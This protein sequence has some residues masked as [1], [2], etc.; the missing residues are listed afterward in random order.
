[1]KFLYVSK[2]GNIW[3]EYSTRS[4]VGMCKD[5][6]FGL[7]KEVSVITGM[8]SEREVV[9]RDESL[10]LVSISVNLFL[11]LGIEGSEDKDMLLYRIFKV[12]DIVLGCFVAAF[13]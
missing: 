5:S 8:M 6:V 12:F 13:L 10:G 4:V 1:M 2:V 7:R 9:G 3:S 11:I